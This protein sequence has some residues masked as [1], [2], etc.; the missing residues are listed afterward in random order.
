M[1]KRIG[2][3]GLNK[4]KGCNDLF[5]IVIYYP[6][7]YYG[8]KDDFYQLKNGMFKHKTEPIYSTDESFFEMEDLSYVAVFM[9]KGIPEFVG[10]RFKDLDDSELSDFIWLLR[11]GINKSLRWKQKKVK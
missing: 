4:T 6:N 7:T 9:R 8:R 1:N 2:R 5:E 10:D 3:I 11:S